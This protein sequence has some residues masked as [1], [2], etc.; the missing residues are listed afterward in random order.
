MRQQLLK[1]DPVE[2][3]FLGAAPA[4]LLFDEND[5]LMSSFVVWFELMRYVWNPASPRIDQTEKK[6]I[7]SSTTEAGVFFTATKKL[8]LCATS[9]STRHEIVFFPD[10]KAERDGDEM[11]EWEGKKEQ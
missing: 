3:G 9:L 1:T 7:T 10:S 4:V 8:L 11:W 5:P 2:K 6:Q